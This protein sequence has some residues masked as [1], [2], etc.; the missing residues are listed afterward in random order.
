[1]IIKQYFLESNN[2]VVMTCIALITG[3]FRSKYQNFSKKIGILLLVKA[4]TQSRSPQNLLKS[5]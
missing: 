5:F 4:K 1:M 2:K 3:L